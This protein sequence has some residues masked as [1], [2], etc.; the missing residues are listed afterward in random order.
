MGTIL[1]GYYQEFMAKDE[2]IVTAFCN[3]RYGGLWSSVYAAKPKGKPLQ[4]APEMLCY[5]HARHVD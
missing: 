4:A 5:E 3:K 2:C 1:R